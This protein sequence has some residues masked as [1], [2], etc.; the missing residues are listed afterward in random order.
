MAGLNKN[1][2]QNNE[3]IY[4]PKQYAEEHDEL[5][6]YSLEQAFKNDRQVASINR[7]LESPKSKRGKGLGVESLFEQVK[8]EPK[9]EM[10]S[11]DVSKNVEKTIQEQDKK[12]TED[13]SKAD[14]ELDLSQ[15]AGSLEE[16]S[17]ED[18]FSNVEPDKL[19]ISAEQLE[20]EQEQKEEANFQKSLEGKTAEEKEKAINDR[21]VQKKKAIAQKQED[22][23]K[24]A[25]QKERDDEANAEMERLKQELLYGK[26]PAKTEQ[27]NQEDTTKGE[28]LQ[29]EIGGGDGAANGS[30]T[31]P[32]TEERVQKKSAKAEEIKNSFKQN[33]SAEAQQADPAVKQE[34]E[35]PQTQKALFQS[36]QTKGRQFGR[37][38]GL[39]RKIQEG[40]KGPEVEAQDKVKALEAAAGTSNISTDTEYKLF[41]K[42][43]YMGYNLGFAEGRN[44][45]AKE[46]QEKEKQRQA[47]IIASPEFQDGAKVATLSVSGKAEDAAEAQS[48]RRG[49]T[50]ANDH[51][52]SE[53][54][55]QAKDAN[56]QIQPHD[57]YTQEQ[58]TAF[59]LG[60]NTTYLQAKQQKETAESSQIVAS[61]AYQNAYE[62]GKQAAERYAQGEQVTHPDFNELAKNLGFPKE[63]DMV[64]K[65]YY[66]G[67]NGN[68]VKA[69]EKA[70]KAQQSAQDQALAASP[71]FME[72][73][74]AGLERGNQYDPD[75]AK[76]SGKG[77]ADYERILLSNYST[78]AKEGQAEADKGPSEIKKGDA[79]YQ[80]AQKGFARGFNEARLKAIKKAQDDDEEAELS[81]DERGLYTF[82]YNCGKLVGAIKKIREIGGPKAQEIEARLA[83]SQIQGFTPP[84]EDEASKGDPMRGFFAQKAKTFYPIP[85]VEDKSK[86]A[87]EI[88]QIKKEKTKKWNDL[89]SK[90]YAHGQRDGYLQG[91]SILEDMQQKG[92]M[93]H[94]DFKTGYEDATA[95]VEAYFEQVQQFEMASSD[96]ARTAGLD[97]LKQQLSQTKNQLIEE[98]K[99]SSSL[100]PD[101]NQTYY[102]VG[103][104]AGFNETYARFIKGNQRQGNSDK[105]KQLDREDQSAI[106]AK[107][108]DKD[109]RE[110]ALKFVTEAKATGYTAAFDYY[111]A[112]E[113]DKS[114]EPNRKKASYLSDA[115]QKIKDDTKI[116]VGD[117]KTIID[118][119]VKYFDKGAEAGKEDGTNYKAG[120][121][122]GYLEATGGT[123]NKAPVEKGVNPQSGFYKEGYDRGFRE[124][125]TKSFERQARGE[126]VETVDD[127]VIL[128]NDDFKAGYQVGTRYLKALIYNLN[129]IPLEEGMIE[130]EDEKKL[131]EFIQSQKQG[132]EEES[133]PLSQS[134]ELAEDLMDEFKKKKAEDYQKQL[135]KQVWQEIWASDD[136]NK[137][138]A[139]LKNLAAQGYTLEQIQKL[140]RAGAELNDNE[141]KAKNKLSNQIKKLLLDQNGRF[142]G[143]MDS[144][145]EGIDRAYQDLQRPEQQSELAR[146]QAEV[147]G[148][149]L[150]YLQELTR[151]N[152]TPPASTAQGQTQEGQKEAVPAKDAKQR[153][154]TAVQVYQMI[155]QFKSCLEPSVQDAFSGLF[156]G[157]DDDKAA[158]EEAAQAKLDAL[159]GLVRGEIANTLAA[160]Q[161]DPNFSNFFNMGL[162]QGKTAALQSLVFSGTQGGKVVLSVATA[163]TKT[164]KMERKNDLQDHLDVLFTE[165]RN[166]KDKEKKQKADP[167]AKAEKTTSLE[168]NAIMAV[169]FVMAYLKSQDHKESTLKK[170][171]KAGIKAAELQWAYDLIR[172]QGPDKKS[173]YNKGYKDGQEA[174]NKGMREAENPLEALRNI[175]T[176]ENGQDMD[177]LT[178]LSKF[179]DFS[180]GLQQGLEP[181][182]WSV[183]KASD[184]EGLKAALANKE[185]SWFSGDPETMELKPDTYGLDWLLEYR[186]TLNGSI[187]TGNAL[188]DL[189]LSGAATLALQRKGM[190][191]RGNNAAI[192]GHYT[193]GAHS[194]RM[195]ASGAGF[196]TAKPNEGLQLFNLKLSIPVLE[197]KLRVNGINF[198]NKAI[199][200]IGIGKDFVRLA[201]KSYTGIAAG[202]EVDAED[203]SKSP[204]VQLLAGLY[205]LP[206]ATSPSSSEQNEQTN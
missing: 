126:K 95:L 163:Y 150:G 58:V 73:Y 144:F 25:A 192:S 203:P 141:K 92:L 4:A 98:G 108:A 154:W 71:I 182:Q 64:K 172:K 123:S 145:K 72:A 53:K 46:E 29:K 166:I 105:R 31:P 45:K 99:A 187:S 117:R 162:S 69:K 89:F 28:G 198:S 43:F 56:Y 11:E 181:S 61:P 140:L 52:S 10:K 148:Y 22:E 91:P 27:K 40:A 174:L 160:H 118:K 124:S 177:M 184:Y 23:A 1:N 147:R 119:V 170:M 36:A 114:E 67:F 180:A 2:A 133:K 49:Y 37:E 130:E 47:K 156:K 44:L 48:I 7:D 50:A 205:N 176:G 59:F 84:K 136:K 18:I 82:A 137:K 101:S 107:F 16:E 131:D 66:Q 152:T 35:M 168:Q 13:L 202:Q 75:N 159:A 157:L 57:T 153:G 169:G 38:Q 193:V 196:E 78:P 77:W 125:E 3:K 83:Q 14:K 197:R 33:V 68:V 20:K 106:Q 161:A 32:P 115:R 9:G 100:V 191:L 190:N 65:G 111:K 87:E 146:K 62:V 85:V 201:K 200:S 63:L 188:A 76:N 128:K 175:L 30:P 165:F 5:D 24:K 183:S 80:L 155:G 164:E 70:E 55:K 12:D 113:L 39:G 103:F 42:G 51:Y 21:D 149:L 151:Q 17:E 135:L 86:S 8:V 15:I 79:N 93:N 41:E 74:R 139:L 90:A 178:F 189:S 134:L 158:S 19:G 173:Y 54:Q 127:L 206:Q 60:F 132:K 199:Q 109:T 120:Y 122:Q 129:G 97:L 104:M 81:G 171:D 26:A 185:Q 94:P 6:S 179:G 167:K 143:Q 204:A 138:E 121:V 88:E 34:P 112:V 102:E 186:G 195:T 194:F 142:S 110:K 116:A 96:A